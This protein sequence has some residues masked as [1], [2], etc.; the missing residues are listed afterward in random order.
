VVDI[1]PSSNETWCMTELTKILLE[2]TL[3]LAELQL[4]PRK[5]A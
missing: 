5:A 2:F 1:L 4:A 3:D